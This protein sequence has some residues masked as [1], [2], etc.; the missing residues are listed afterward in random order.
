MGRV[1]LGLVLASLVLLGT[2]C[3][4]VGRENSALSEQVRGGHVDPRQLRVQVRGLAPRFCGEFEALADDIAAGTTDPATRLAMLSFK[5]NSIPQMQMALFQADPIAALIDAWALLAQLQDSLVALPG[6]LTSPEVAQ[7]Q[8]R[9]AEMEG[10]LARIWQGLTG[11]KDVSRYQQKIH[12]WAAEHPLDQ[13]VARESTAD[14]LSDLTKTSGLG[15]LGAAGELLDTVQ[16]LAYRVDL[17]SAYL[18]K[19]ARWQAEYMVWTALSDPSLTQGAVSAPFVSS[20]LGALETTER[21]PAWADFQRRLA[22]G[23]VDR[24]RLESLRFIQGEREAVV[25]ELLAV[26]ERERTEAM[27]RADAMGKGWVDRAGDR[28]VAVADRFLVRLFLLLL[29]AIAGAIL[30]ALILRHRRSERGG[31]RV[32]VEV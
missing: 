25:Q 13:L 2:A 15:L 7:A 26:I 9:F 12:A 27:A 16:D 28:A 19:Q 22:M 3:L 31:R 1:G 23:E 10:E 21:L 18:P 4:T 30:V 24:Q 5:I 6:V 29:L 14:L 32:P 17:Q 8:K 11:D 20:L